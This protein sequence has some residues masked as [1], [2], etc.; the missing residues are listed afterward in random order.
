[1]S[2]LFIN[3]L[4]QDIPFLGVGILLTSIFFIV[5]IVIAS[6]R[7]DKVSITLLGVL[8]TLVI[9]VLARLIDNYNV[10]YQWIDIELIMTI[11]GITLIMEMLKKSGLLE[12]FILYI[13]RSIRGSFDA[14][15]LILALSV[16]IL[17]MIITNVLALVIVASITVLIAEVAEFDP[18]PILFL[19]LAIANLSGMLTPIASYTAA[20]VSLEQNWSYLDF[21]VLSLPYVSIMIFV[22]ILFTRIMYQNTFLEM[23]QKE[24]A[25]SP[26]LQ[27]LVKT[28]DPWGFVD[29]RNDFYKA[30]GIFFIVTVLLAIGTSLGVSIDIICLFGGFMVLIFFSDHVNEFIRAI[31][32]PMLFFLCGIFIMSG[33]IQMTGLQLLLNEPV[34]SLLEF[35]PV[36]GIVGFS[37]ILGAFTSIIENIP[38]IFLLRPLIDL[39]STQTNSHL[40]WWAILA[41]VNITDS[42]I[43]ISSVKGIY[44]MEMTNR[45]GMRISFVEY[46]RYGVTVTLIHL[47]GMACYIFLL[48]TFS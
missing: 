4:L 43:L 39:I 12:V 2:F 36:I 18:K 22:T 44:I 19:E 13:L 21:L 31:D 42:V 32:W 6:E 17:S 15:T 11:V 48:F 10:L 37:W 20:Y 24:L 23:K 16:F 38:L 28:I 33:L 47:L 1:M 3:T 27:R 46:F 7:I 35:S 25:F 30:I 40:V 41:V 14:L 8:V 5:L 9:A 45:E 26:Q 29:S 34:I